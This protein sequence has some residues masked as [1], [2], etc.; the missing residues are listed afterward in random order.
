MALQLLIDYL[1]DLHPFYTS[2]IRSLP[3]LDALEV[4]EAVA[5]VLA[6]IPVNGLQNAL[7]QFCLPLAQDLHVVASK[8]KAVAT[9]DDCT[10]AGGKHQSVYIFFTID[11]DL[12]ISQT[13]WNSSLYF[14]RSS[15]QKFRWTSRIHVSTL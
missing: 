2:I 7:Q 5:H 1:S 8:E 10:K 9:R 12:C 14:S 11:T 4:T 13:C 6:V 15:T 3:F